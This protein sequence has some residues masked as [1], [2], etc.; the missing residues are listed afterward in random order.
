MGAGRFILAELLIRNFHRRGI[1]FAAHPPWLRTAA[2]FPPRAAPQYQIFPSPPQRVQVTRPLPP[3]AEQELVLVTLPLPP[4][5]P[6]VWLRPLDT[7]PLPPHTGQ[8]DCCWVWTTPHPSH[9][10]Q[11]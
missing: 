3:Q 5:V 2:A 10:S 7:L 8:L 1:L 6:Q 4:Q 9:R 11:V